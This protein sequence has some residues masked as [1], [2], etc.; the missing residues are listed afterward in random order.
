[1][2][3]C[4]HGDTTLSLT[5]LSSQV[6]P[7]CQRTRS[8]RALQVC[9][10]LPTHARTH[11]RTHTHTHNTLRTLSPGVGVASLSVVAKPSRPNRTT[12]AV[13]NWCAK[14][15]SK[16]TDT[17]EVKKNGLCQYYDKRQLANFRGKPLFRK[18]KTQQQQQQK[19]GKA[20]ARQTKPYCSAETLSVQWRHV[21]WVSG[22]TKGNKGEKENKRKKQ[23]KQSKKQKASR[24]AVWAEPLRSKAVPTTRQ[25]NLFSLCSRHGLACVS[26]RVGLSWH[27]AR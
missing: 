18:K 1:M 6:L 22:A 7:G 5:F 21:T 3:F 17:E 10:L 8:V 25:P 23:G 16:H 15:R 19:T 11:A 13:A 27:K 12:H 4:I 26:G 2:Y 14:T 24:P 9:Q 20:A